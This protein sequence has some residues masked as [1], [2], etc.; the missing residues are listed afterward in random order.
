MSSDLSRVYQFLANQGD[1]VQKADI[2]NDDVIVKDEFRYLMEENFFEW[3]GEEMSTSEQDDLIDQFWNKIDTNKLK[4]KMTDNSKFYNKNTL[5]KDE[6][7][8]MEDRI[9]MYETLSEFTSML[10]CPS[11]VS[12]TKQWK[13]DVVAELQALLETYIEQGG[14]NENL[15]DF[16]NQNS[17]AI[18]NKVTAQYCAAEY[19]NE[20]MPELSKKY[21]YAFGS[22]EDLNN[23]INNYVQNLPAEVTPEEMKSTLINIINAYLATAGLAEANDVDLNEYGYNTADNAP[24]NYLQQSVAEQ[25]LKSNLEAVKNDANYEAYTEMFDTAVSAFIEET[26]SNA[27]AS[28]FQT[29]LSYGIEQFQQSEGYKDIQTTI[30]IKNVL[31]FNDDSSELYNAIESELGSTVAEILTEGVYFTA[32]SEIID[33]AIEQSDKFMKDGALDTAALIEWVVNEVQ[34]NLSNIL[35]NSG[36]SDELSND[37]L[38]NLFNES[39]NSADK[40]K[41]TDSQAALTLVKE[42]AITYCESLAARGEKHTELLAYVFETSNYS[43]VINA[44]KAPS[45]IE[46]YINE[47]NSQVGNIKETTT[48][49]VKDKSEEI[50]NDINSSLTYNG[51]N[52][53]QARTSLT[54]RVDKSGYILFVGNNYQESGGV[55]NDAPDQALN[56]LINSQVRQKVQEQYWDE[57]SG[58]GLTDNELDN[59][60]NIAVFMTVSNTTVVRS[61]YDE[62]NIGPVIEEIVKNYSQMLAKVATDETARNYIKNVEN[63]SLLNGTGTW[64]GA[65]TDGQGNETNSDYNYWFKTLDK[66]YTNDSTNSSDYDGDD[67]VSI[68][69]RGE[70]TFSCNGGSGNIIILTSAA[71]G[72]NDPVNK[73]MRAM[74]TDYVSSYGD[75]LDASKIIALFKEAQQTAFAKL[76][77]VLNQ[78]SADGAS[79]YGYGECL[80]GETHNSDTYRSD[81]LYGVNSI[82]INIMYEM[83]RLLSKEVLGL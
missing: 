45:E 77:S 21:E 30:D 40:L 70:E 17:T 11:V 6:I 75:I 16:L 24:L 61:M 2:N 54:F 64:A 71:A 18:E 66:Y 3:N 44:C 26:L 68:A 47:I 73:A 48:V 79:I 8:A 41:T 9:E 83:E 74:L 67:W 28:D 59:L 60:Y 35:S 12:S 14:T 29:I 72:D 20:V 10:D 5:D 31:I 56:D 38:Y 58:L 69:S 62:M 53:T 80:N 27:K 1:W 7:A 33:K 39:L 76:E 13:E 4:T 78:T 37:E 19:L 42:A 34:T 49:K 25:T 82:L 65:R 46:D 50:I 23:L 55:W 63:K 22:D 52:V 51:T 32:Y 36:R 57:I 81:G 15:L 43:S